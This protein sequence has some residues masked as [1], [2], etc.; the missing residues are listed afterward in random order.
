MQI[1]VLDPDQQQKQ[2]QSLNWVRKNKQQYCFLLTY[3]RK[4]TNRRHIERATER[5]TDDVSEISLQSKLDLSGQ[6]YK[7]PDKN[8]TK[9]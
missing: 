2:K 7:K 1:R 3:F 8:S 5:T 6:N 4:T 9:S